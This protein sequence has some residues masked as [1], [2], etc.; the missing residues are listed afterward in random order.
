[1]NISTAKIGQKMVKK[2]MIVVV[3]ADAIVAQASPEDNLHAKAASITQKLARLNTQVIYPASAI[4]EA[5]THI[6]KVLNNGQIAYELA[7]AFTDFNISIID[8][9]RG[10]IKHAAR[11][12]SPK[13]SKK[14]TFFDCIVAAVAEKKKADAIFSFDGFY[15]KNGFK[16]ASEL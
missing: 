10:T 11:F 2:N 7:L 14:N 8:I 12:F 3:D 5:I 9:N 15:K 1:M 6:Q 16:L 13:T 4:C